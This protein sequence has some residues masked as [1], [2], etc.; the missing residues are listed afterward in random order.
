[1][2]TGSTSSILTHIVSKTFAGIGVLDLMHNGSAAFFRN[3][4]ATL[5]I[6]VLTGVGFGLASAASDWI[7]GGCLVYDLV[8]LAVGQSG[9][10][11]TLLSVFAVGSAGIVVARNM[12]K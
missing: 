7:F 9:D 2:N 5:P 1:M 3:Q 8:A 6:K 4:P 11:R 10:W 12:A